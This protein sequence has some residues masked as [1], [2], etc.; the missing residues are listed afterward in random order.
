MCYAIPE[1]PKSVATQLQREKMLA[2]E[3]KYEKG[4]KAKDEGEGEEEEQ[5]QEQQVLCMLRGEQAGLARGSQSRA[6]W[7]RRFSRLSDT[8]D[9][10]VDIESRN[11]RMSQDNISRVQTN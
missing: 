1:V 11:P 10:H 6:S 4:L 3:A 7:S 2:Q 9:A 5:Q 8:L